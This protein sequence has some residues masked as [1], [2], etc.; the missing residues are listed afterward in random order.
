MADVRGCLIL[1]RDGLVLGAHPA[2][3]E[4][5]TTRAWIRFAAI[6]DPERGFAQFGTETW[7]YVR[8][9][10][11]C[12]LRRRRARGAARPGDR[13]HGAGAARGRGEPVAARGAARD[14]GRDR[15]PSIQTAVVP[16]PRA[17]SA[18]SLGDRRPGAH[19]RAGPTVRFD[20]LPLLPTPG[21]GAAVMP[22][23]DGPQT[24]EPQPDAFARFLEPTADPPPPASE[25]EPEAR[26]GVEPAE[27]EHDVRQGWEHEP[28]DAPKETPMSE[29]MERAGRRPRRIRPA[30]RPSPAM[31]ARTRRRTSTGSRWRGSSASCFR[32]ARTLPM[33]RRP[34]DRRA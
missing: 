4:R 16:A 1:S 3:S 32:G 14:R 9:G 18:G 23:N 11:V 6:G 10:P 2:E 30:S 7:C 28:T 25:L 33:V 26:N 34:R 12:R 19:R 27:P 21:S 15:G 8:R 29:P 5:T 22:A 13:P 31:R 24:A 20:Q 17:R